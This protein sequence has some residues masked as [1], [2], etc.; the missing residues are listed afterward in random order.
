MRRRCLGKYLPIWAMVFHAGGRNLTSDFLITNG[1]NCSLR[2]KPRPKW[3]EGRGL[4]VFEPLPFRVPCTEDYVVDRPSQ[5][6]SLSKARLG[7]RLRTR[8]VLHTSWI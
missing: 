2:R 4:V 1:R 6:H 8:E 5:L 3:N 7:D